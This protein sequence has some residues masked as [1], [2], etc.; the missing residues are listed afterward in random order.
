M[1]ELGCNSRSHKRYRF[2]CHMLEGDTRQEAAA[3]TGLSMKAATEVCQRFVETGSWLDRRMQQPARKWTLDVMQAAMDILKKE[4]NL[5]PST[6][7][8]AMVDKG[9]LASTDSQRGFINALHKFVKSMGLKMDT[10]STKSLHFISQKDKEIRYQYCKDM[11]KVLE[12]GHLEQL[13]FSD[14]TTYE[15]SPH[16]KGKPGAKCCTN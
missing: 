4:V 16:P 5:T 12:D 8:Q 11:T 10:Q 3:K 7:F 13:I 9:V 1:H 14:E 2:L 6:L 15:E